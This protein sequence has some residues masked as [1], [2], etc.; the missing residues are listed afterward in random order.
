MPFSWDYSMKTIIVPKHLLVAPW[1]KCQISEKCNNSFYFFSIYKPES[2][3]NAEIHWPVPKNVYDVCLGWGLLLLLYIFF[4]WGSGVNGNFLRGWYR[5]SDP[6]MH[7]GTCMTHVPWCMP[8]SLTSGF[9]WSRWRVKRSRHS[10]CMCNTQFYVSGKRPMAYPFFR[11]IN[12]PPTSD[13]WRSLIP[14]PM[15]VVLNILLAGVLT[16]PWFLLF[17]VFLH[18]KCVDNFNPSIDK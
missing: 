18:H 12:L 11:N 16:W 6:D 3:Q 10:R 17:G 7:H 9:L 5:V 1:S 8:G 15:T 13:I 14:L 4:W 2:A